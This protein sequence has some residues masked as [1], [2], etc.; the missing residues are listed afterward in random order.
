MTLKARELALPPPGPLAVDA[1]LARTGRYHVEI[2][3]PPP[4]QS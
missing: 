4:G 1:L 3:G 2:V